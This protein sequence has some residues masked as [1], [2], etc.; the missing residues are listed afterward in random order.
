[1]KKLKKADYIIMAIL[2][3]I[4]AGVVLIKI[5]GTIYLGRDSFSPAI[6]S[7]LSGVPV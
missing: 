3:V 7:F 4:I 2:V 6:T 1:M 5:L